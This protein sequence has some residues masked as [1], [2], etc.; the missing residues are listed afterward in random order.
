MMNFTRSAQSKVFYEF[1]STRI[2]Q[3]SKCQLYLSSQQADHYGIIN[4]FFGFCYPSGYYPSAEGQF[5]SGYYLIYLDFNGRLCLAWDWSSPSKPAS[6]ETFCS[7][8]I[9]EI[10]AYRVLF[11]EKP[12]SVIEKSEPIRKVSVLIAFLEHKYIEI[13]VYEGRELYARLEHD[14]RIIREIDRAIEFIKENL[15]LDLRGGEASFPQASFDSLLDYCRLRRAINGSS[16]YLAPHLDA[17]GIEKIG[18]LFVAD[19]EGVIRSFAVFDE[20]SNID[21]EAFLFRGDRYSYLYQQM[22]QTLSLGY[23]KKNIKNFIDLEGEHKTSKGLIT[24]NV[25]RSE[26]DQNRRAIASSLRLELGLDF[27]SSEIMASNLHN[28]LCLGVFRDP[29]QAKEYHDF[30]HA[31]GIETKLLEI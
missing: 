27:A 3:I 11:N 25:S 12:V 9:S 24:V 23:A 31:L 30:W 18:A 7:V 10:T 16:F 14:L 2:K 15:L 17:S 1:N 20:S 22:L 26:S 8:P 6:S 29:D 28:D 19:F 13:I 5:I 4:G 21:L